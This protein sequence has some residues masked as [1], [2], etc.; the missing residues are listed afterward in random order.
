MGELTRHGM[1]QTESR[2]V[3]LLL[4]LPSICLL[5]ILISSADQGLEALRR[6]WKSRAA[7]LS[8]RTITRESPLLR[9]SRKHTQVASRSFTPSSIRRHTDPR[10]LTQSVLQRSVRFRTPDCSSS[11]GQSHVDRAGMR[12]VFFSSSSTQSSPGV[13]EELL[14]RAKKVVKHSDPQQ[15]AAVFSALLENPKALESIQGMDPETRGQLCSIL[16]RAEQAVPRVATQE[17][18]A[19]ADANEVS[20][21]C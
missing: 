8:H 10:C 15:L 13:D 16:L 21:Q 19:Q 20:P 1:E 7:A 9:H 2:D 6:M 12:R 14:E 18:F 11:R 17:L 5:A 4:P 3:L